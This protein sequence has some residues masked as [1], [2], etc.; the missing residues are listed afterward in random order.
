MMRL[1]SQIKSSNR[2]IRLDANE[3][4]EMDDEAQDETDEAVDSDLVQS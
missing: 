2:L 4:I 1:K 3:G